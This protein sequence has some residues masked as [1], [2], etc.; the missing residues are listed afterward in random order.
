MKQLNNGK[1]SQGFTLIELLIVIAVLGILAT[2]I[3]T[4]INTTSQVKKATLVK[5]KKLSAS[6][7]NSLS[8]SQVGKWSFES[9]V[10][11]QTPDTS[12]YGNNGTVACT[13]VGC[14]LPT[15]QTKDQCGLGLGGCLSFDG[16]DDY[17]NVTGV[18]STTLTGTQPFTV[19]LWFKTNISGTPLILSTVCTGGNPPLECPGGAG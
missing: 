19:S 4:V 18:T 3:L 1:A 17:V 9:V 5:A 2:G 8:L 15:W 16:S 14:T 6:I 10:S 11:G 7:E 13:G 12:G